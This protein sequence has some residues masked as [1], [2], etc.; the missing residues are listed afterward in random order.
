MN[1]RSKPAGHLSRPVVASL[2]TGAALVI[3]PSAAPQIQPST[4][5][6]NNVQERIQLLT[7]ALNSV[8]SQI[9][10]SQRE[11]VE[12]RRK[13]ADLRSS[14]GAPAPL[15]AE[16]TQPAEAANLA[17]AVA[18]IRESQAMQETQIATLDQAKVES[19]SRYPITLSG[20]V[21]FNGFVNTRRV[22]AAATPSVS[23]SGSGSTGISARQT[24]VGLDINGPRLF[25][26]QTR[27]DLR[28]DL[29]AGTAG[30]D[31]AGNSAL[32]LVRLRTAHID[33]DWNRT[34]TYFALDRPL[35]SPEGPS[36]LTAIAVPALAWSGN[37][38]MWSPQAGLSFD[39]LTSN[40]GALRVQAA[41]IDSA[42]PPPLFPASGNGSYT[43]PST[44]ELSRWP[45]VEARIAYESSDED[46]GPRFG[47]SGYFAPHRTSYSS[48]SFES[49]AGA[50]DFRIPASRFMQV[51]GSAYWG[52]ALG[53]LGGGAYK[54]YAAAIID[55][56]YYYRALDDRGGWLQWK[57]KASSRLE[58]NEAFGIDNVPAHQLRPFAIA[59]P[60]S[61][62]NLARNRTVT[63]NVIYSPSSYILLSMEYR[64]IMSSY[65]TAPSTFS[66]V[67][68][69]AAGYKF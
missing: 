50:V 17:A 27:G 21:V 68:G 41:L 61:I 2:I 26:A 23:L 7:D 54:D 13:I 37:L 5:A 20:M 36:S 38:W 45:G 48:F 3:M 53:G 25:G 44:A 63:G 69:V 9:E 66:N 34:H 55:G 33:F 67:I 52:S 15:D 57:Q 31:Y 16:A 35:I 46:S 56:E 42:D 60:V 28:L 62:Y 32:G 59:T 39:A 47:M 12:L 43:P 6:A 40:A 14:T 30:Y 64:R 65:V 1:D 18:E 19:A 29:N 11:L 22:D 51:A 4:A 49:W 58:F 8:Q 24:V 10:E